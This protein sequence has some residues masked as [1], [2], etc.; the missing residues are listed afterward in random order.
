MSLSRPGRGRIS[1]AQIG[2][3][4]LGVVYEALLAYRGFFTKEDLYEVKPASPAGK[5]HDALA[6]AYFMP[7]RDLAHHYADL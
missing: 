7:K 5:V 6:T 1:Y 3:N 2:I 4:Q